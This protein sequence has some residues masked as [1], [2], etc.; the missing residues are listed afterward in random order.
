MTRD[1]NS[2]SK[3]CNKCKERK[4]FE[5]FRKDSRSKS[6]LQCSCKECMVKEEAV[7]RENNKEKIKETKR[8]YNRKNE[9]AKKEYMKEYMSQPIA[10]H[11]AYI[12]SLWRRYNITEKDLQNIML[13][14]GG[15]CKLCGE[16]F[17]TGSPHRKKTRVLA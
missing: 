6:G 13:V 12:Q 11:T 9:G 17:G 15:M 3:I 14:Q 5:D 1:L 2:I 8:K 16:D 7:Y 4:L 10:K